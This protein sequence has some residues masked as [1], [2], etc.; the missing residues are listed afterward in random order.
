MALRQD[1]G[2][3]LGITLCVQP[4]LYGRLTPTC[5][6]PASQPRSHEHRRPHQRITTPGKSSAISSVVSAAAALVICFSPFQHVTYVK[7]FQ[8]VNGS[9]N[10]ALCDIARNSWYMICSSEFAIQRDQEK[11]IYMRNFEL[12][13]ITHIINI[14]Y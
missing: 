12:I 13:I 2:E 7:S 10:C 8:R 6:K 3:L 1:D 9:V 14:S 11:K 4:S 5:H